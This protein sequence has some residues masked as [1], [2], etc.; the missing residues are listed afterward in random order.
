[1]QP[2]QIA[3][4]RRRTKRSA[5]ARNFVLQNATTTPPASPGTSSNASA[6]QR[7]VRQPMPSSRVCQRGSASQVGS[8]A[9]S[10]PNRRHSFTV[11]HS[12]VFAPPT[13]DG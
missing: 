4:Q 9:T 10:S 1:M 13:A 12:S 8:S 11:C 3:R 7:I 6:P 5:T 2:T